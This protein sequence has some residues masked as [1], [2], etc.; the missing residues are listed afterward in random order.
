MDNLLNLDDIF[1]EVYRWKKESR[2]NGDITFTRVGRHLVRPDTEQYGRWILVPFGRKLDKKGT[3]TLHA[4]LK[5]N[6]EKKGIRFFLLN[7]KEETREIAS[8]DLSEN[9]RQQVNVDFVPGIGECAYLVIT[10]TDF[11]IS[12]EVLTIGKMEVLKKRA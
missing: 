1:Y 12:G 3:Y 10:A 7:R 11:P 9:E 5:C 8:F 2:V 4:E 6:Y